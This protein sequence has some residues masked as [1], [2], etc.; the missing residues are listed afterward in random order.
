MFDCAHV[1]CAL[2]ADLR[3]DTEPKGATLWRS[4]TRTK[5]ST[6]HTLGAVYVMLN[7]NGYHCNDFRGYDTNQAHWISRHQHQTWG[8]PL[9]GMVAYTSSKSP[10]SIPL[11]VAIHCCL[12]MNKI[13]FKFG[14]C[15][16]S[17]FALRIIYTSSLIY[18]Q[19]QLVL[20]I[21]TSLLPCDAFGSS[22][23]WRY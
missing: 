23:R 21:S 15:S 20:M 16:V 1:L 13:F 17:W 10:V 8:Y 5:A 12:L 9:V 7:L 11:L 3:A 6:A 19:V 2:I 22:H 14:W 4:L 18:R